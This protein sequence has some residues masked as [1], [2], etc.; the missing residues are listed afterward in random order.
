[1]DPSWQADP[2]RKLT[3]LTHAELDR[4]HP[5]SWDGHGFSLAALTLPDEIAAALRTRHWPDG[6]PEK[7]SSGPT[8]AACV[9]GMT[10]LF[11]TAAEEYGGQHVRTSLAAYLS[12]HALPLVAARTGEPVH[13]DLLSATAQLTLLLAGMCMDSGQDRTAQHYHQVAVRL[14]VEADDASA[15]AIALRAMATH[16][17]DLGHHSP[18]VLNLADQASVYARSTAPAVQA[19]TEAQLAVLLAH[20]DRFAAMAALNRAESLYSRA[21]ASPGP[22]T[23]YPPGALH[24][25]RARTLIA[26]GDLVGAVRALSASVRLRTRAEQRASVLTRALLADVHLRLG[27]LD[28]ALVHGQAFLTG[29]PALHSTR[30]TRHLHTLRKQLRPHQR[31]PRAAEFLTESELLT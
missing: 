20:Y 18:A 3:Q 11:H 7:P 13:R 15:L 27:H 6:E 21:E 2:V 22:F 16:S 1:M 24:Y 12:H 28:E 26:L 4:S 29:Y 19:Y 14:A 25:Q 30:A 8:D 31:H 5:P 9:R 17:Y 10:R 23:M